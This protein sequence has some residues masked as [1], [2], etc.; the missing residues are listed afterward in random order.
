[1]QTLGYQSATHIGKPVV[2]VYI[3]IY[4]KFIPSGMEFPNEW[5]HENQQKQTILYI[6]ILKLCN[7]GIR[8]HENAGFLWDFHSGL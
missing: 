8:W 4:T 1:M 2:S 3:Y 6:Y 7:I 5:L